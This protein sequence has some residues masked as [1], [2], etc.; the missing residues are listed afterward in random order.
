MA[1][2]DPFNDLPRPD[3]TI[4]YSRAYGEHTRARRGSKSKVEVNATLKKHNSLLTGANLPA[5]LV[6]NE[7]DT[8]RDGFPSGQLWQFLVG[9]FKTQLKMKLPL[10]VDEL[11]FK[12]IAKDYPLSRL[13]KRG[14][15]KSITIGPS[16]IQV[17]V[18]KLNPQFRRKTID[19]YQLEVAAM[20]FDFN[21]M[22]STSDSTVSPI[23]PLNH[24][25]AVS[26]EL[27]KGKHGDR[28][29]ISLK[30]VGCCAGAAQSDNAAMAMQ[31]I[32]TGIIT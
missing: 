12:D 26:F 13:L 18:G 24:A 2:Y 7:I 30:I 22:E 25:A 3:R 1:K 4:V 5:R 29:L 8:Y 32:S 28:F 23:V 19:G 27:N 31:I 14:L 6:K 15:S 10:N 9:M 20:Y 17:T 21:S 11:M 16:T